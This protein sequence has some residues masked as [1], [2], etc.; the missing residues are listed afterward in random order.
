MEKLPI[1]VRSKEG[2]LP[3]VEFNGVEYPDSSLAIRDL[4]PLLGKESMESHMG[5]EEKAAARAFEALTEHSL[6]MASIKFRVKYARELFELFPEG[7]FNS[8]I[9]TGIAK[10][11]TRA[12]SFPSLAHLPNI[13]PLA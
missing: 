8:F 3:F 11:W 10:I 7:T 12:V 9:L 5:E 2:S 1:S 13:N 4:T 6:L